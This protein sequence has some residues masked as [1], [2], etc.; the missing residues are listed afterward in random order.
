MNACKICEIWISSVECLNDYFLLLHW[1]PVMQAVTTAG[2]WMKSISYTH[3]VL[4]THL[5]SGCFWY[6]FNLEECGATVMWHEVRGLRVTGR[7]GTQWMRSHRAFCRTLGLGA[8]GWLWWSWA[9]CGSPQLL[10]IYFPLAWAQRFLK[11]GLL[12]TDHVVGVL[13]GRLLGVWIDTE[14][15]FLG[16]VNSWVFQRW[17]GEIQQTLELVLEDKKLLARWRESRGKDI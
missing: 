14:L 9:T 7:T 4:L 3:L 1:I 12:T 15:G 17:R 11:D 10:Q 13:R 16:W 5:V 8:H 6:P 2:N